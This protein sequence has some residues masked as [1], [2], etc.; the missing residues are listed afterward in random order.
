MFGNIDGTRGGVRK[1][2]GERREA[3]LTTVT[4]VRRRLHCQHNLGQT[5]K[6]SSVADTGDG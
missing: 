2:E 3:K 4:K 6:G 1:R 5:A